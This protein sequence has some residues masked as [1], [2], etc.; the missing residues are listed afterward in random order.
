MRLEP[1]K[2]RQRGL[3]RLDRTQRHGDFL[4][5]RHQFQHGGGDDA[6]RT[7]RPDE[8]LPQTIPG[9]VLAQPPQPVPDRAIRQHHL[10]PQHQIAGVAITH[11]VVA[12]GVHRQHAADLRGAFGRNR[13]RQQTPLLRRRQLCGF[14]RHPS[15]DRQRHVGRIEVADAVQ[16]SGGQD[17]FGAV[18]VRDGAAHHR[19]VAALWNDRRPGFSAQRHHRGE[20]FRR[21]GPDDGAGT[22]PIKAAPVLGIWRGIGRLRQ[23]AP[24]ADNGADGI[25]QGG[26]WQHGIGH[27]QFLSPGPFTPT[28]RQ[29]LLPHPVGLPPIFQPRL[30]KPFGFRPVG[31]PQFLDIRI[32]PRRIDRRGL[33]CRQM[34]DVAN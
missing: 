11:R 31:E 9:I 21:A 23:D 22:P 33:Q 14:Q 34:A 20:F 29:P 5:L 19:R 2:Q 26:G 10:Q 17:Q 18:L 25:Q 28:G 1:H 27:G 12:A 3:G 30:P 24:I 8:Q 7:L 32:Q 6:Q 4:W 15:L 13:Q 16:P